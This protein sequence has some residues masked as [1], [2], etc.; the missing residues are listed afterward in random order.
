MHV[1]GAGSVAGSRVPSRKASLTAQLRVVYRYRVGGVV[2]RLR[3]T[4]RCDVGCTFAGLAERLAERSNVGTE[5]TP[6]AMAGAGWMGAHGHRGMQATA[7][8]TCFL[9]L[10][11]RVHRGATFRRVYRCAAFILGERAPRPLVRLKACTAG[12]PAKMGLDGGAGGPPRA[13]MATNRAIRD[14]L[15]GKRLERGSERRVGDGCVAR[16]RAA[17]PAVCKLCAPSPCTPHAADRAKHI[18]RI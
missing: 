13:M 4:P 16:C 1:C 11:N 10:F 6:L 12:R 9:R 15:R 2:S 14:I 5:L 18:Q 8:D 3:Q 7:P 17:W